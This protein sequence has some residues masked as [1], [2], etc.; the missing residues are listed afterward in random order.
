MKKMIKLAIG[1]KNGI[2]LK[3]GHAIKDSSIVP[4]IHY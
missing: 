2:I 3:L 4:E 1:V